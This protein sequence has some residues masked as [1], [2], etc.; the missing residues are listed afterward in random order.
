MY[1]KKFSGN[2]FELHVRI[3]RKFRN[4]KT[5]TKAD[6][7]RETLVA[8]SPSKSS[9]IIHQ[10]FNCNVK[11]HRGATGIIEPAN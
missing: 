1:M 9:V 11:G 10:I 6:L 7:T 2:Y 3:K 5:L 4:D 8:I